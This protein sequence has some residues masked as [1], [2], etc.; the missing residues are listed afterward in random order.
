M[1]RNVL[2]A[3]SITEEYSEAD[4]WAMRL[5][6]HLEQG[7]LAANELEAIAPV[8]C[9]VLKLDCT[10]S[11][12]ITAVKLA[13]WLHDW[14]K[15]NIDFL[16]LVEKKS[17]KSLLKML[18]IYEPLPCIEKQAIR[19]E[20]LSCILVRSPKVL[21]WLEPY[22]KFLPLALL[23]VLGHHLKVRNSDYFNLEIG[24]TLKVFTQAKDF[25]EVLKLGVKHLGL[26]ETLPKLP[27]EYKEEQLKQ[28]ICQFKEWANQVDLKCQND[29]DKLRKIATVKALT[30]ACDLAAS[31]LL[32]KHRG[33]LN[34]TQWIREALS[35]TMTVEICQEVIESKL[36]DRQLLDFQKNAAKSNARVVIVVA[37]C[38]AGKSL[39]AYARLNELAI[40]GLKA[41]LFFCYPT[42]STT[43]QGF[44][45]YAANKVENA[46]LEHSRKWVD[47]Q[48]RGFSEIYDDDKEGEEERF[49]TRAEALRI[50]HSKLIYCT[51]HTVLGLLQNYRKGL[52]G[53]PAIVQ[54]FFVFDEIHAYPPEL[55]GTLLEFLRIF[56]NSH[57]VLMTASLPPSRKEAIEAALAK[58]DGEKPEIIFGPP[59]IEKLNRYRLHAVS[60]EGEE[61]WEKA[62]AELQQGGKVLWVTNE[63]YDCQRLYTEAKQRFASAGLKITP[64]CFHSRF[65]YQDSIHQQ[66]ELVEA[67]RNDEPAF[68][69]TTQIAEMSLDISCTLLISAIA[70]LWALIQRLGRLNRWV[71]VIKDEYKLK[72]GRVCHALIYQRERDRLTP[73]DRRREDILGIELSK[74]LL[75]E[76]AGQEIN[77]LLLA[78]SMEKM[79][80]IPSESVAVTWL[81]TWLTQQGELMPPGYTIQVIL[82]SDVPKIFKTVKEQSNVKLSQQAQKWAVS[83]R[84]PKNIEKWQREKAF[85]FYRV[86]LTEDIHYHSEIGAYETRHQDLVDIYG[87][88]P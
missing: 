67:F 47:E 68:A 4:L 33:K 10:P 48:L 44:I 19:H 62:I 36:G 70:P 13:I 32:E 78:E 76:Y 64:I 8:I 12:L 86:A 3:K 46:L 9:D 35:E 79:Q 21:Q 71:D 51:A 49:Q 29:F 34:Y 27:Q 65:R 18:R 84:S 61:L 23:A 2:L 52:Y 37:G 31:A 53:F 14:G 85:K 39:I 38:G 77:Q 17:K 83:V 80:I 6:G 58:N 82:E 1:N 25:E 57:I 22:A 75:Q 73:Y 74:Q 59:E 69:V 45:D 15:V 40:N 88:Q 55:F 43:T 30:M 72:T 50:W 66:N 26:S 63:V 56:R 42:T 24:I 54:G 16:S 11:E 28:G 7:I 41:K 5:P 60:S 81:Q 20:L 87:H